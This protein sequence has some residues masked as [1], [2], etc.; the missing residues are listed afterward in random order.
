[1]TFT[2]NNT[3]DA[4]DA[5]TANNVCATSG[6]VCTL[7]AAIQQANATAGADTIN[8]SGVS[9]ISPGSALPTITETVTISGGSS[10]S[11][12]LNGSGAGAGVNGLVLTADGC[13]IQGLVVRNFANH[14]IVVN[15]SGNTLARNNL[16]TDTAGNVD[17]GNGAYGLAVTGNNNTIGGP[18]SA[19]QD[20]NVISGNN[21]G[22]LYITGSGNLVQSNF[23]GVNRQGTAGLGNGGSGVFLSSASSNTFRTGIISGNAVDGIRIV[24]G[25]SNTVNDNTFI[26]LN[27]GAT[28][29][30]PN[31]GNGVY[32]ENSASN[33]IG[34]T[35]LISGNGGTGVYIT[36]A[37]AT[38]NSV[39]GN[40]IGLG[41]SPSGLVA[42]G[43]AGHGVVLTTGANANTIGGN[44]DGTGN[45]ISGNAQVGVLITDNSPGNNVLSNFIGLGQ[46]PGGAA[47]AYPNGSHGVQIVNS[48]NNKIGIDAT[49]GTGNT[50]SGNHGNGVYATSSNGTTIAGNAIGSGSGGTVPLANSGHGV[51]LS[52]CSN[53]TIGGTTS[54]KDN[55]IS[56]NAQHG[57]Y[58]SG[59]S[60]NQILNNAIGVDGN[61]AVAVPNGGNGIFLEN[62]T[63]TLITTVNVSGNVG[64]GL[65]IL[66]GSGTVFR[67]N[68]V[69]TNLASTQA[70]PNGGHGVS[71][72]STTGNSIGEPV[73]GGGNII[74][75]NQ[76]SGV[77]LL[78]SSNNVITN[79]AIGLNLAGN[80]AL[81]NG[82]YGILLQ[83]SNDNT[84]G[85]AAQN[86]IAGNA[87]IGVAILSGQ[88]NRVRPN[89][90]YVNG[91]IAIDLDRDGVLPFDGVTFNDSNDGDTGANGLLNAPIITSASTATV[92]GRLETVAN[93]AIT[94][95]LYRDVAC[96]PTLFGEG[97]AYL[98]STTVTTNANGVA[99]WVIGV[100]GVI[101]SDVLAATAT[102]PSLNT[103]EMSQCITIGRRPFETLTVFN[104]GAGTGTVSLISTLY[105]PLTSAP[106]G[107]TSYVS[108][109]PGGP[110][111]WVMGDW[112]GDGIDTPAVYQD[113]GAFRY[114]NDVGPTGNWTGIWFGLVGRP[115]VAGRFN[116]ALPNDCLG[117]VDK[118]PVGADDA[119]NLY[120]T[121]DLTSGPNPPKLGQW[122]SL[123]LPNSQGFTGTH[124][125]DA[126][127]FD[128]NGVDSVAIRRGSVITW[129]NVA[130]SSGHA[131]F[132]LAQYFGVPPGTTGEG[133]FVVGDWNGDGVSSFGLYYQD[134]V[135]QRRND[136]DWNS[137]VYVL[138]HVGQTIGTPT[139]AATWRPGGSQP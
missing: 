104:P 121:C 25:G 29:A 109:V 71:L 30:I 5:N 72:E 75:G 102:D 94:V 44:A 35:D 136:I 88:R 111:K 11:I 69:G 23:I 4:G 135:F 56:G 79:N 9:A 98:G 106:G 61:G 17:Q 6:G 81:P 31:G 139:T 14:G 19:Y 3:G 127:D 134:G 74:S 101:S 89:M 52:G 65:R 76:G 32:I 129:T 77:S 117:V 130:P 39:W 85:G 82:G 95:D 132:N 27:N 138:Q 100:S 126:G 131:L 128:N 8:F 96:D 58:I 93:T 22:G 36:G 7:R 87:S 47:V 66:G 110:G 18:A 20:R 78:Q 99:T 133:N 118:A 60:G 40:F 55:E 120:Y 90:M 57:V 116:P 1:V 43:N 73:S 63:G 2:V 83:A 34:N 92:S 115:P 70:I 108:G 137:G 105:D 103:S 124:Q 10:P 59:G 80:M 53:V 13:V 62:V 26:G 38:G 113:S 49:T 64:H 42:I 119:F 37:S 50:I 16:G 125:F 41:F 33:I 114:T 84:I 46:G 123:V 15:S 97:S 68:F 54:G 51:A 12:T 67:G 112:D 91:G 48:P 45:V 86:V 107:F 21:G 28:A 24:G 122:L